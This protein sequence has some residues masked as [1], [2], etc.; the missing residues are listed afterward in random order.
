MYFHLSSLMPPIR[1]YL[2]KRRERNTSFITL[3]HTDPEY[4][5]VKTWIGQHDELSRHQHL[6]AAT[7]KRAWTMPMG[8]LV[9]AKTGLGGVVFNPSETVDFVYNGCLLSF[10]PLRASSKSEG[11]KEGIKISIRGKD[12]EP[13][14]KFFQHIYDKAHPPAGTVEVH[15]ATILS[16]EARWNQTSAPARP[17]DSVIFDKKILRDAEGFFSSERKAFHQ[18]KGLPYRRGY[19]FYGPPG[20]GKSSLSV[21]LATHFTK[22]IYQLG[23]NSSEIT[24]SHLKVLFKDLPGNCIL[25]VE[26]I[27]VAGLT[28]QD[29]SSTYASLLNLLDGA[30]AKEGRL[31]IMTTNDQDESQFDKALTRYGRID[32]RYKFGNADTACLQRLFMSITNHELDTDIENLAKEFARDVPPE[33][34]SPAAVTDFLL[35]HTDPEEA[36]EHVEG[37]IASSLGS[38]NPGMSSL[39]AIDSGAQPVLED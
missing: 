17:I 9:G 34:F 15:Y 11:S 18:T 38:I 29:R 2:E 6:E 19:L 10:T 36:L 24:D 23:L 4:S 37:W 25:L 7:D 21:A 35:E 16:K 26:D 30:G 22:P 20:T 33:A 27:R 3:H 13:V 39:E 5:D 32:R 1:R 8:L 12:V 28:V 14:R 31:L